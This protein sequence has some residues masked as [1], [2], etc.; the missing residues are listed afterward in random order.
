MSKQSFHQIG[1]IK[2]MIKRVIVINLPFRTDR[3]FYMMGHLHAVGVPHKII[4]FYPANYGRDYVNSQAVK[5]AAAADGFPF[6]TK[7]RAKDIEG[8]NGRAYNWTWA[9]ILRDIMQSSDN[10][11]VILDDILLKID[12]GLLTESVRELIVG[13]PEFRM[14]QVGWQTRK[15]ADT[16]V[17]YPVSDYIARG[18]RSYGD[19]ATVL[20]AEGAKRVLKQMD[21]RPSGCMEGYFFHLSQTDEDT[22]GLFHMIESKAIC[23]P[24]RWRQN[25]R[26]DAKEDLLQREQGA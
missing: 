6:F 3:K 15:R 23:C 25:L 9:Q 20:N 21:A 12:W 18:I 22:T 8:R 14:L 4:E 2:I 16:K 24:V 26:H 11:L 5:E 19:Y 13:H 7:T 1:D 17:I 10:A